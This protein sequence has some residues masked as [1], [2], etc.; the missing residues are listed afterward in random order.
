MVFKFTVFTLQE[1][2]LFF[3]VEQFSNNIIDVDGPLSIFLQ[4]N[5]PWLTTV[6]L[7][8]YTPEVEN[9][10]NKER[11][12]FVKDEHGPFFFLLKL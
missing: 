6:F 4:L 10:I 3:F 11:M 8:Y 1:M 12:K 2:P 5:F 7:Q 9:K